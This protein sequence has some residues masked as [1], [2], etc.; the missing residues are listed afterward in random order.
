MEAG[1]TEEELNLQ[2]VSTAAKTVLGY[3]MAWQQRSLTAS[4]DLSDLL[5]HCQGLGCRLDAPCHLEKS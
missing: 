4:H 5:G 2:P 3:W 1:E